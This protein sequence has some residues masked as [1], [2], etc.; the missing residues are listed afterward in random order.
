[1]PTFRTPWL[2]SFIVG[3]ALVLG[4][5]AQLAVAQPAAVDRA[6]AQQRYETDVSA[7]NRGNLPA[8]AREACVR[9]AGNALDRTLG[10]PPTEAATP[11]ADGRA[12]VVAPVGSN[13]P[14]AASDTVTSGDGRATI[15]L[16][17]DR[18]AAP[19]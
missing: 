6:Q 9:N 7:C 4:T 5:S 17:A 14:P 2:S 18:T 1:M 12:T 15:V 13:T 19:R 11:S 8:P 10:G 16:P 3:S